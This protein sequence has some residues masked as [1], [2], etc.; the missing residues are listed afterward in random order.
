MTVLTSAELST[1]QTSALIG[2]EPLER[3]TRAQ[4]T[5]AAAT[6]RPEI[7]DMPVTGAGPARRQQFLESLVRLSGD[8]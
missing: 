1:Y 5:P 6:G 7:A 8:E 3:L 2:A 4:S